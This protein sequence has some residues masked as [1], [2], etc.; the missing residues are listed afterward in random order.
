MKQVNVH[1][2]KTHLA[3]LLKEVEAGE[4]V[5]IARD[6]QPVAKLTAVTREPRRFKVGWAAG[7]IRTALD[8]DAP[9][10][11]FADYER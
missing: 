5:I 10:T 8:F 11:D 4:T 7:R 6:N 1:E 9:L 3:R 2:A